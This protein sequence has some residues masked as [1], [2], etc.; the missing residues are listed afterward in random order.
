MKLR[1]ITLITVWGTLSSQAAPPVRITVQPSKVRQEFQG[2]G[3]GAMFYEGHI[4]SLA[5]R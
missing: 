3:C 2:L 4:T 5:T 1:F